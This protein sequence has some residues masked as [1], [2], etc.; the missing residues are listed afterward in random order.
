MKT[1]FLRTLVLTALTFTLSGCDLEFENTDDTVDHPFTLIQ[2][3]NADTDLNQFQVLS[4]AIDVTYSTSPEDSHYKQSQ[5]YQSND[6]TALFHVYNNG[7]KQFFYIENN[8]L[9]HLDQVSSIQDSY[10]AE[11]TTYAITSINS[12]YNFVSFNDQGV[13]IIADNIE[14]SEFAKQGDIYYFSKNDD[15]ANTSQILSFNGDTLSIEK[16]ISEST[17][18]SLEAFP[19]TLMYKLESSG[20]IQLDNLSTTREIE[21][22]SAYPLASANGAYIVY[23]HDW[24]TPVSKI[25]AESNTPISMNLHVPQPELTEAETLFWAKTHFSNVNYGSIYQFDG[26]NAT[27]ALSEIDGSLLSGLSSYQV[28]IDNTLY[29]LATT[30]NSQRHILAIDENDAITVFKSFDN[31]GSVYLIKHEGSLHYSV[32]EHQGNSLYEYNVY[33]LEQE[34][35]KTLYRYIE[36]ET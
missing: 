2:A 30:Q 6:N 7:D 9:V 10:M 23:N 35:V 5:I 20:K 31:L 14:E 12:E 21:I 19:D 26:D 33:N 17:I 32:R 3:Y 28:S 4:G 13:Q 16:S 27:P 18:K 22:V 24:G 25:T 11:Q 15:E 8:T 1:S 36:T 34:L 29:V